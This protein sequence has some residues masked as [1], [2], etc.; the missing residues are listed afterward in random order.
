MASSEYEKFWNK[1]AQTEEHDL[2]DE[3]VPQLM[4]R[5]IEVQRVDHMTVVRGL[6]TQLGADLVAHPLAVLVAVIDTLLDGTGSDKRPGI[7]GFVVCL[8]F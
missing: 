2:I 1:L 6:F 3:S 8:W 7:S 5:H 4:G